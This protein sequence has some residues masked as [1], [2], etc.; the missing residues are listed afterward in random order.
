[1]IAFGSGPAQHHRCVQN[2]GDRQQFIDRRR[3]VPDILLFQVM[4]FDYTEK[5]GH[6]IA[7]RMD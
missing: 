2:T 7:N 5:A 3:I 4:V 1:M 6:K